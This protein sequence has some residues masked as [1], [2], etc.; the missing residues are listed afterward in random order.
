MPGPDLHTLTH[1]PSFVGEVGQRSELCLAAQPSWKCSS[2]NPASGLDQKKPTCFYFLVQELINQLV[3]SIRDLP[4]FEDFALP[5]LRGLA[6]GLRFQNAKNGE[7]LPRPLHLPPTVEPEPPSLVV[8]WAGKAGKYRRV[9]AAGEEIIAAQ[10]DLLAVEQ[11]AKKTQKTGTL[12]SPSPGEKTEKKDGMLHDLVP[13]LLDDEVK[14]DKEDGKIYLKRY[15]DL[16]KGFVLGQRDIVDP[17]GPAMHEPTVR[18]EGRCKILRLTRRDYLHCLKEMQVEKHRIVHA[19]RNIPPSRPGEPHHRSEEQLSLL[20]KLVRNTPELKN[21]ERPTLMQVLGAATYVN[22]GKG[23]VLFKQGEIGDQF[24][25]IIESRKDKGQVIFTVEGRTGPAVLRR[26][27]RVSTFPHSEVKPSLQP[28][29]LL[30]VLSAFSRESKPARMARAFHGFL[31][32]LL[33]QAAQEAVPGD[34]LGDDECLESSTCALNALQMRGKAMEAEERQ[35]PW[36]M[37]PPPARW[38]MPRYHPSPVM[39]LY[40]RPEPMGPMPY[41][42]PESYMHPQ[43]A[44]YMHPQPMEPADMQPAQPEEEH[45]KMV[46]RQVKYL[47]LSPVGWGMIADDEG[48]QIRQLTSDLK[49]CEGECTNDPQCHSFVFCMNGGCYLKTAQFRTGQEPVHYSGFCSTYWTPAVD[50]SQPSVRPTL[51]PVQHVEVKQCGKDEVP[52]PSGSCVASTQPELM[53]FYQYSAQ[54]KQN[55]DDRVW[56]NV[57]FANIGG[58]MFYLHNEVVDKA[59]EMRNA[60]G[61]RTPKFNIDRILRFKVTM[62]NPDAL[63]KKYRSQFGQFIQFDYGQATFGMPDH[64]EKCNAIWETIGYEVGCQPN[65]VGISGYDGGYWTSW[66]GRCPSMPFSD[67]CLE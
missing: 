19:L 7:A 5:Q 39:P 45:P 15:G 65:P 60:E 59:G 61:D 42:S 36:M 30:F 16:Q 37:M 22:A 31:A 66:P 12:V 6:R 34:L 23:H 24:Y 18:C 55:V 2:S 58:V 51:P 27:Q 21:F 52:E 62:K 33:R 20:A 53:T 67:S 41:Y 43:P 11:G 10:I 4:F 17:G 47:P 63:W 1:R 13:D 44:T 48:M 56:E 3:A 28:H 40:M 57:N 46:K 8:L 38:G 29:W 32:A 14:P 9:S 26:S 50:T 49:G 64:V 35:M 25:A 54:K